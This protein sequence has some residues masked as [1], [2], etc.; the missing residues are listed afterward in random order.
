M[1]THPPRTAVTHTAIVGGL[2][3]A[4]LLLISGLAVIYMWPRPSPKSEVVVYLSAP[5]SSVVKSQAIRFTAP[6]GQAF[7]MIDGG[8]LNAA[9]SPAQV[10]WLVNADSG[11]VA[12][13][14]DSSDDGCLVAFDSNRLNFMDPCHGATYALDGRVL[15]GPA[16]EPL[17]HLGWR[18]V[19]A[20]RIAVLSMSIAAEP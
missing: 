13:A 18:Q 6:P 3:V 12:L 9:G 19:R 2:C 15:H 20:D 14:A 11:L 7:V 17:A 1:A 8:G 16:S 4:I 5:I 10:G